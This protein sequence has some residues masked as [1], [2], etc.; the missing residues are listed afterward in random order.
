[1]L[2]GAGEIIEHVLLVL[3]HAGAVPGLPVLAA[4][5]QVGHGVHAAVLE[6][7]GGQRREARRHVDVE[8]AIAVEQGRVAAVE[9]DA[10]LV[11]HEHRHARA[12]FGGVPGLLGQHVA[13]VDR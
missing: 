13:G 4:A 5:P 9:R 7:D 6:P 1:M 3:A 10:L 12:V 2:G 11:H 8:A